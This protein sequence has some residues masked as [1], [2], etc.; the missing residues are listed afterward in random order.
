M[1][2][3]HDGK[4][5]SLGEAVVNEELPLQNEIWAEEQWHRTVPQV[6]FG[7]APAAATKHISS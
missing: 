7:A 2:E 4:L 5:R 6:P 3:E 1:S